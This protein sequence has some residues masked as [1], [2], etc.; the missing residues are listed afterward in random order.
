MLANYARAHADNVTILPWSEF[1][2]HG[3]RPAT[4]NGKPLRPDGIHFDGT[5]GPIVAAWLG[6]RLHTLAQQVLTTRQRH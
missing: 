4:V 6:P 1:L 5:S 3:G 2:C